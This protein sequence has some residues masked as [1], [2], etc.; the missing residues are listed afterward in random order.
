VP[1]RRCPLIY[2]KTIA[3]WWDLNN[4]SQADEIVRLGLQDLKEYLDQVVRDMLWSDP[5]PHEGQAPDWMET[6]FRI[7]PVHLV[8]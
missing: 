6:C 7:F 5:H 4:C 2:I 8:A 1:Q 3:C